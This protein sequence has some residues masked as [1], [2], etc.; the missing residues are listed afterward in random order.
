M[1][2]QEAIELVSELIEYPEVDDLTWLKREV[3]EVLDELELGE[4]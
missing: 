4:V 2:K 1:T 3:C